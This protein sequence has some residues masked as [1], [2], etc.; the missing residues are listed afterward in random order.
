MSQNSS[1]KI[2]VGVIGDAGVDPGSE[3]YQ[4]ALE[5]GKTV[6]DN[7]YRILSG[8]MS[9]I[10]E[11]VSKGA[12][13]STK[14][15]DGLCIGILPGFDPQYSNKYTDVV[16]ATGLD[17]YRNAIVANSDVVIAMG[18]RAG[19]LSEMA[20]AWTFKRMILA[21]KVHGWSGKLAGSKIDDRK[22]ID[23]EGDKV[24]EISNA[25]EAIN[26]IKKHLHHYDK[27]HYSIISA[28]KENQYRL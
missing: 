19:T 21:Y 3:I 27:R 25:D 23:W 24:F 13:K 26:L 10:M 18:G 14:Y 1:R 16:I 20:F 2:N 15:Y 11:A 5:L 22:R 28:M 12:K 9:G 7:G 8:G 6:I 17:T 4:L